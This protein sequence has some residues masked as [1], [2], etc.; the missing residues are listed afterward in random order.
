MHL[1]LIV[2]LLVF[3]GLMILSVPIAYCI[4]LSGMAA[5]LIS[6]TLPVQIFAQKSLGAIDS[7]TVLAVPFFIISGEI[8][9]KGGIARRLIALAD[10]LVG[11]RSKSGMSSVTMV[12]SAL[13]GAISGSAVATTTAIGGM[14]YPE[15]V[16]KNYSKPFASAIGAVA[17]TLG[18]LIP[19][20]IAAIIYG[21]STNTSVGNMFLVC[22][23]VGVVACVFYCIAARVEI[24]WEDIRLPDKKD[25][26]LKEVLHVFWDAFLGLMAP[27]IILGGIYGGIFTPTEAAVVAIV[28]SFIVCKFIYKELTMKQFKEALVSSAITTGMV[29]LLLGVATF[30]S[31]ILSIEKVSAMIRSVVVSGGIGKTGFLIISI[32]ILIILGMLMETIPIIVLTAPILVPIAE[33]FGIPSLQFGVL[34]VFTLSYGLFTPPF[35]MDVFVCTTYSKQPVMSVFAKCRW[36]FVFGLALIFLVAFVPEFYMWIAK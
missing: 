33:S 6:G 32:V 27:V 35:G 21:T 13:F 17:G 16:N 24:H 2:L 20:S 30:F 3:F 5:L 10:V 28:Y 15:M 29:E 25:T 7:F 8:M 23:V 1:S 11:R 12:A 22:A 4:G 19:P 9:L 18:I 31:Y 34:T 14:M 36:F 26:S